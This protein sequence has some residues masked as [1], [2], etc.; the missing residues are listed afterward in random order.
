VERY[1]LWKIIVI[2]EWGVGGLVPGYDDLVIHE[3]SQ[4]PIQ[5]VKQ[6]VNGT[7]VPFVGVSLGSEDA[8]WGMG[9]VTERESGGNLS[10]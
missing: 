6:V 5:D 7:R 2:D 8:T 9:G 3:Q 1:L 4:D 10:R